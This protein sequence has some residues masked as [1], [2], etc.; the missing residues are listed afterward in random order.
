MVISSS[1]CGGGLWLEENCRATTTTPVMIM[2]ITPI[3]MP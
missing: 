3:I 1:R 2:A